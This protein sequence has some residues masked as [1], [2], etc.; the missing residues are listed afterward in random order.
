VA[1]ELEDVTQRFDADMAEYEAAMQ[2][3]A[4]SAQ[5]FA[6]ANEEAKVAADGLR[7]S[8]A[9][10][11]AAVGHQR[12]SLAEAAA[13]LKIY[14]DEQ[15]KL[16]NAAGEVITAS[17]A[18]A[19]ALKHIRDQALE[20]SWAVRDLEKYQKG[21]VLSGLMS[22][23][24]SLFSGG[25]G[26]GGGGGGA[27]GLPMLGSLTDAL[28]MIAA[29]IPLIMAALAEVGALATGLT[30]AGLGV[31]GF[32]AL[33]LPAFKSVTTA[34]SQI[35]TD[36]Q[37]YN[38]ALTATA[39][40]T[41]LAHLKQDYANLSP[42]QRGAVEGLQQLVGEYHKLSKAFEPTAFKVFNEGL[43]IANQLLPYVG[44]FANAAAPAIEQLL[45]T[46][47]KGLES[48]AF[49]YFM[50]FLES[51]AGPVI[52]AVG[53]GLSGLARE[54]MFLMERFSEKDVI[55]A[56]N[57]AFRILGFTIQLVT[58][59]IMEGMIAWDWITQ[60]ALPAVRDAF[61]T[62]RHAVAT[63]GHDIATTFDTVRHAVA[64]AGHDI[65][66]SF[67][68]V[69]HAAAT[70][71]HDTVAGL[72]TAAGWIGS[73]WKEIVAWLVDPIGM[74]DM[75]IR[76]H[77]HQIAQE[78]DTMRHD[79]AAILDGARH[80]AASAWDGMRHDAAAFA[81]WVPHAIAT[82][83]DAARHDAAAALDGARHDA[84]AAWDSL[85]AGVSRMIGDVL[86]FFRKL[87]GEVTSFLAA[88][89]GEMLSIG[90]NVIMG[91]ING[92]VSAA[93][94]IPSIMGQLAGDVASYF[95]DPLKLFSPSRL[96]FEHGYNIVQGAINGVKANA[97]N[98]LALMRG[99]GGGAG[100]AGIGSAL[101][102][103]AIGAA[104]GPVTVHVPVQVTAQGVTPDYSSPAFLQHMQVTVQEAV[105]RYG[106][107]N[108]GNGLT[109]AWGR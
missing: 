8:S 73:H 46:I 84:A 13:A 37:A 91:L 42:A 3:G 100:V 64:T 40:N 85:V 51:L 94:A 97:P 33:A 10:A 2:E 7:D 105:L 47:S 21:G 92:I 62:T 95:T 70:V 88:L 67:D 43:Q 32:A 86:A 72:S 99:L 66:T 53:S 38:R 1:D 83:F 19:L 41:A 58:G 96:F 34:Y 35:N 102:G 36:Q 49:K 44:Q 71:G 5:E 14:R 15:G 18:E 75:E 93:A 23:L 89:P 52:T 90:R 63:A 101:A 77:T 108:P 76:T 106:M 50:G 104:G 6:T 98:L 9:E 17:E 39:R 45:G 78:F 57:I 69:R 80:D 54:V 79:A 87:P 61:D 59:L 22:G 55:N 16:R 24:G 82:G 20:A 11:G 103:G 4:A 60:Q 30:A 25:G 48:P 26:A 74:A 28:P 27:A 56:V 107:N 109:P 65:A 68:T 29:L 31:G 81:D 12:D